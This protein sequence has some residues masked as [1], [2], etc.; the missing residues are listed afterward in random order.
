MWETEGSTWSA[1]VAQMEI[2]QIL[3]LLIWDDVAAEI[4]FEPSATISS[5]HLTPNFHLT[6]LNLIPFLHLQLQMPPLN[7][8]WWAEWGLTE[9]GPPA[10]SLMTDQWKTRRLISRQLRSSIGK[11]QRT[12]HAPFAILHDVA[13]LRRLALNV[14]FASDSSTRFSVFVWSCDAEP[15]NQKLSPSLWLV[16]STCDASVEEMFKLNQ[17]S[18]SRVARSKV[19]PPSASSKVFLIS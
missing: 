4:N 3:L 15:L 18:V 19:Y 1:C 16:S 17:G 11:D 10:S 2:A 8:W 12:S 14:A 13:W 6:G 5:A 9:T 7:N